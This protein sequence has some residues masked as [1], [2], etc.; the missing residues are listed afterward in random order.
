MATQASAQYPQ[1]PAVGGQ[2]FLGAEAR[3]GVQIASG[4]GEWRKLLAQAEVVGPHLQV[5]AIE[6]E[7]GSGKQ[8]LARYLHARS[9][10]ARLP[11]QRRDAREWLATY[12][13]LAVFA[14]FFYLDRV[15]LL[16]APEQ[17]RLLEILKA[18][19]D[20]PRGRAM[21]TASSRTSFRQL[22]SE[23]MLL[24]DLASRLT[25]MRFA[26][27]PLRKRREDIA[28]LAQFLLEQLR[29][30][31]RQQRV[32]FG[33][34]A[35]ARLLQHNWPGNVR[36]LASVLEAAILESSNGVIRAED[37]P[38]PSTS[39]VREEPKAIAQPAP[40][41]D[42]HAVI[43]SHVRYVLDLNR[44]NKLRSARQ[45]GISRSTLYRILGDES[46]LGR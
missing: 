5:A 3:S 7:Q 31:H 43:L 29:A 12:V 41:L 6:G 8:T 32:M 40:S 17:E 1:Q 45:L 22:T 15:D 37:L 26:V 20:L 2:K 4:N 13:N 23:G 18:M 35:L 21:L 33:P 44:G 42:L 46:V 9:L 10:L 39:E 19:Q 28:A 24:P 38:L 34:G 11:F 16:A 36:E 27:P 25:A 30:R 14:G